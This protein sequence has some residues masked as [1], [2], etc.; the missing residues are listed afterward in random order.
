MTFECIKPLDNEKLSAPEKGALNKKN[1]QSYIKHLMRTEQKFSV[2]QHGDINLT[3]VAKK[4]GF[5]RQVFATNA[6]MAKLLD[7]AVKEIGTTIIE[8]QN[9]EDRQNEELI[10]VKKQLNNSLRDLALLEEKN[11]A[12]NQQI[13]ELRNEIKR[14]KNQSNENAESLEYMFE[15]GRRFTI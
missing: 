10:H 15:T 4:C 1:L 2:N 9:P 5:N 3:D 11:A 6:S 12:F 8:G 7:D 14:L 13:M